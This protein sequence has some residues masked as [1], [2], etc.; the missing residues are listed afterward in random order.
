MRSALAA[1]LAALA[2]A[3]SASANPNLTIGAAEDAARSSELPA[4]RF[5][6]GLATAAG[7]DAVRITAVWT[8]GQTELTPEQVVEYSTTARA[9]ALQGV[10]LYVEVYFAKAK[11]VPLDDA[12]RAQFTSYLR[13]LATSL[14]S[15]RDVIVGNEP[16]KHFFWQPQYNPD[17]TS[18]APAAYGALL[19]AA[20]DALKAVS[21]A[22]RVIGGVVS[23]R[24]NDNP[25]AVSNI[26]HSP[27]RFIQALGEAYR[28]SGRTLPIMDA[29][30]IHPYND[31]SSQPPS[32]QHPRSTT[33]SIG[34]Y[35][36]LV[37]LLGKAFDGTAQPG[38]SLPVVYDEYGIQSQ[39]PADK[40]SLYENLESPVAADA[41]PEAT[42]GQYYADA[43]KLAFCQPNVEGFFIFHT[44]DETDAVRWQSGLYYPDFAQKS[45]F[46]L[47]RDTILAARSG[48][49][50]VCP[51]LQ[52]QPAPTKVELDPAKVAVK[53]GC[54]RDCWYVADL[55]RLPGKMPV[56]ARQGL[57]RGGATVTIALARPGLA[58]GP[59]RLTVHLVSRYNAGKEVVQSSPA[60]Q[61]G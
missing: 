22:I 48:S 26:S 29:F 19:A 7:L 58:P 36:K 43:I 44:V 49:L 42:R 1:A 25:N 40:A 14:P 17:G 23:A 27:T 20:Y 47:L 3:S 46:P 12:A 51:G 9:A 55:E 15:V 50:A 21:P 52:A 35:G 37:M 34:D 41:V 57:A 10:R 53:L 45:D 2:V 32:F 16:N 6:L 61:V 31:T 24:G 33:V 59:Y 8:A 54:A 4:S 38:S 5:Q 13:S 28:A 30:A 56:V 39:V 11:E 18:A 60:F